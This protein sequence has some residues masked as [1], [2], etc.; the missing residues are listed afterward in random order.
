LDLPDPLAQSLI[1]IEA[2]VDV[3]VKPAAEQPKREVFS[4]KKREYRPK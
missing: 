3:A 4:T 1:D 2:A